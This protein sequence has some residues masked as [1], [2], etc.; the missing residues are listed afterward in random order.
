MSAQTLTV[1][2]SLSVLIASELTALSSEFWSPRFAADQ[3]DAELDFRR[4]RITRL[5]E[6]RH[7]FENIMHGLSREEA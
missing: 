5:R 2:E 1:V 6:L 4:K 3:M 7:E